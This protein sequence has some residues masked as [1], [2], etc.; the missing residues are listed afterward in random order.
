[1]DRQ[2]WKASPTETRAPR[3]PC[4][5]CNT[6]ILELDR[7]LVSVY[8]TGESRV[9]RHREDWFEDYIEERFTA[10]LT[11]N[12]AVCREPV[13]FCGHTFHEQETD[14]EGYTWNR[15]LRPEYF[16]PA[17]RLISTPSG[18]PAIIAKNISGAFS[19]F[20]CDRS[21]CANRLRSALESLLTVLKVKRFTRH[22]P[23]RKGRIR[24]SLHQRIELFAKSN[25]ELGKIMLAVKWLGNEGSHPGSLTPDHLLDGFEMFEY[26]L[27]AIFVN[28]KSRIAK[29]AREINRR[30]GPRSRSTPTGRR[31]QVL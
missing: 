3:W 10:L 16:V 1:M 6:G 13:V 14:A 23:P 19:L 30:K 15:Y 4:P 8:E 5:R 29:I 21:S 31:R 20:W 26:L 17:L 12:R 2:L 9:D 27:D 25:A 11:C 24:L 28:M 7:K 18:C 22:N